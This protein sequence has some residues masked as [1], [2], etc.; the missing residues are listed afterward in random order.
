MKKSG[1]TLFIFFTV[2]L[3]GFMT[4]PHTNAQQGPSSK[5]IIKV[6]VLDTGFDFKSDWKRFNELGY[7]APKLCDNSLH[8]DFT[9]TTIQDEHGHG[10]HVAGIIAKNV[11]IENYCLIIIKTWSKRSRVKSTR[12]VAKAMRYA[13]LVG[14]NIINYSGGGTAFDLE[15]YRAVKS[16][17][18][19]GVVIVAAAGNENQ[20]IDYVVNNVKLT[21]KYMAVDGS[22]VYN[23]DVGYIN[24]KSLKKLSKDEKKTF[25]SYYPATYDRRIIAVTNFADG[26]RLIGSN[27]GDAFSYR[28]D[29][30]RVMSL[31]LNNTLTIMTGTSQATPKKTAKIINSW[32][33]SG[34]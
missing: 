19:K 33:N 16:V 8:R 13:S 15:E 14:A 21:Y 11:I 24:P 5:P 10:T 9:N 25:K 23:M 3:L 32:G 6:A 12:A 29:G 18:D 4:L 28:E 7:K 20:R 17:I 22:A 26:R 31:G 1:K 2:A 30:G 27:Y 34:I